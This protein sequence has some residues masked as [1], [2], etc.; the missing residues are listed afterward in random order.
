MLTVLCLFALRF[1]LKGFAFRP[2]SQSVSGCFARRFGDY[3]IRSESRYKGTKNIGAKQGFLCF[4]S[5]LFEMLKKERGS[6]AVR[7][8]GISRITI[9]GNLLILFV[10]LLYIFIY[11]NI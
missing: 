2:V 3:V 11:Y 5:D 4:I 8:R 10:K 1:S 9:C 7:H 6:A